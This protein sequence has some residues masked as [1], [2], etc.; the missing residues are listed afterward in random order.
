MTLVTAH[1][2]LESIQLLNWKKVMYLLENKSHI[3][4][5]KELISIWKIPLWNVLWF[6]LCKDFDK[7]E[8]FII[9]EW[10]TSCNFEYIDSDTEKQIIND[11]I[12]SLKK[13][14]FVFLFSEWDLFSEIR[15]KILLEIIKENEINTSVKFIRWKE[16]YF[17]LNELIKEIWTSLFDLDKYE[18]LNDTFIQ[19]YT[20]YRYIEHKLSEKLNDFIKINIWENYLFNEFTT[21]SYLHSS[22]F[23]DI[24][25]LSQIDFC[26]WILFN[27]TN[28]NS[29]ISWIKEKIWQDDNI[30]QIQL[31]INNL[32][33]NWLIQINWI[34]VSLSEKW[35]NILYS[36]SLSS[37]KKI[38]MNMTLNFIKNIRNKI[39]VWKSDSYEKE[40]KEFF[41]QLN[42]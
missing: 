20:E 15:Q 4:K 25:V 9:I 16:Q 31:S 27:E 1:L 21:S 19:A 7:K 38:F 32:E 41:I 39:L 3:S 33:K 36:L 5:I 17:S 13:T 30:I 14:D 34:K 28:I 37:V 6:P 8:P 12:S 2:S 42:L 26:T 29:I 11:F 24:L 10:K 35:K 23:L 40:I 22:L 18:A